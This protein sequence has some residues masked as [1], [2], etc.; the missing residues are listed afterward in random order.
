MF[1][2]IHP[3]TDKII[4]YYI[5]TR[6]HSLY[7]SEKGCYK[8]NKMLLKTFTKALKYSLKM[9]KYSKEKELYR[10]DCHVADANAGYSTSL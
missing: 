10:W 9:L 8:R 7:S 4:I 6:V 2:R 3:L 1:H 5:L